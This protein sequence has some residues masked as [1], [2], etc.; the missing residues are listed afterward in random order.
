MRL[1]LLASVTILSAMCSAADLYKEVETDDI[2]KLVLKSKQG[3]PIALTKM[4][5]LAQAGM[6]GV[7]ADDD[8]ASQCF[9]KAA[10]KEFP[11]ALSELGFMY[12]AGRGVP[13]DLQLSFKNYLKAAKLGHPRAMDIVGYFYK[14][15]EG[16]PRD[17]V[18]AYRWSSLAAARDIYG[19]DMRMNELEKLMSPAERTEAQRLARETHEKLTK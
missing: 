5:V 2:E 6:R 19:A 8:Y 1:S 15:G 3:D 10:E 4:G 14:K 9:M 11:A 12:A 13:K 18:E 7:K 16:V 17:Y